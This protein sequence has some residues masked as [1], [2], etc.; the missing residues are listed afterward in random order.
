MSIAW[1]SDFPVEW[2]PEA[3]PELRALPRQHP[4]TWQMVLL[5]EFARDP[6]LE[7]HIILLRRR[8]ARDLTFRQGNA[9]FHVLKAP[10]ALRLFSLFQVDTRL[11]RKLLQRIQPDLVHAWGMEKGAGLIASRLG[12]PY[13]FTVQGLLSWYRQVAPLSPYFRVIERLER[14]SL[15][16]APVVTTE[17]NFAVRYLREQHPGLRVVQAE[18][19][20]N[21]AFFRVSRRPETRPVHF[22]CVGTLGLR[23]GTDLLVQA[24]AGL[25]ADL[26]FRLTIICGPNPKFEAH[27]RTLAPPEFWSK[28]QFQYHLLPHEVAAAFSRPTMLLLPTRADTSPNAVKEAAVAGLPV[29]ATNVGGIPDYVVPEKNGLLF[30][31]GDLADL[32]RQIQR[33]CAHPLFSRGQVDPETL[34]RVRDYLSPAKMAQNFLAAYET[35]V[36]GLLTRSLVK[37][38]P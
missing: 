38:V 30:T 6:R 37:S 17:S 1:I 23:K 4:A 21:E 33:A 16:R 5:S 20:P 27:L 35:A 26:D 31:P 2:L 19:A 29:V 14:F 25:S 22:I 13:V 10:G 34:S 32:R 28:V 12:Y 7:L 36:P 11:I 3:P 8:V 18:H 9:T 24:L 15:P